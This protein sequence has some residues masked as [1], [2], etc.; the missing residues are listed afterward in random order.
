MPSKAFLEARRNATVP[1][2]TLSSEV[3]QY[4]G[5]ETFGQ[6]GQSKKV[7]KLYSQSSLLAVEKWA[8]G[9]VRVAVSMSARREDRARFAVMQEPFVILVDFS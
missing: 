1:R 3:P 6:Q 8:C 9:Q 4:V 2:K 7:Q 5:L